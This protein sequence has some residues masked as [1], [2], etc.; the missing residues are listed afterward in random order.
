MESQE[1][2]KLEADSVDIRS[3]TPSTGLVLPSHTCHISDHHTLPLTL[4]RELLMKLLSVK[5]ASHNE[6][7]H[8]HTL[9]ISPTLTLVRALVWLQDHQAASLYKLTWINNPVCLMIDVK[10]M[11]YRMNE[12]VSSLHISFNNSFLSCSLT[13]CLTHK[14]CYVST[15]PTYVSQRHLTSWRQTGILDAFFSVCTCLIMKSG[16]IC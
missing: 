7:T 12:G 14:F 15:G 6:N 4:T 9:L 1:K 5:R 3:H 11:M 10:M 2:K 8:T 16:F 13:S